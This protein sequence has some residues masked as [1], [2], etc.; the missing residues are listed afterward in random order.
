MRTFS[1]ELSRMSEATGETTQQETRG[2][3]QSGQT[4]EGRQGNLKQA[5]VLFHLLA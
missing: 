4:P 2:E 3:G 5:L 1:L